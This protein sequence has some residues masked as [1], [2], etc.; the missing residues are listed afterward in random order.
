MSTRVG[1]F[2]ITERH[3]LTNPR[4]R[5]FPEN[6][7]VIIIFRTTPVTYVF[8]FIVNRVENTPISRSFPTEFPTTS[9]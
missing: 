4:I 3:L 8:F 1:V 6:R 2:S 5:F 7:I 9:R